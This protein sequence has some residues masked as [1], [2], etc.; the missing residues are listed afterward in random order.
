MSATSERRSSQRLHLP[1]RME[2][3]K[4]PAEA[5]LRFKVQ[6]VT[7]NISAGGAYFVTNHWRL[8]DCGGNV[9]VTVYL[10]K[11]SACEAVMWP[12]L[13]TM[14]TVMRLQ[15]VGGSR[16]E[17]GAPESRGIAIQFNRPLSFS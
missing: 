15:P 4:S 1:L 10:N 5:G 9:E 14:A 6:V 8:F 3:E 16:N 2:I 7:S 11:T 17:S 12:R 13:Q